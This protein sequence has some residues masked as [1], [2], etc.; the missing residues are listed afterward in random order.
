MAIVQNKATE[1]GD[2]ILIETAIPIVGLTALSSFT[3]STVDETV[4]RSFLRE[5]RYAINGSPYSEWIELTNL[6]L[7]NVSLDGADLLA[8]QYRYT[9]IGSDLTDEL[10]WNS[11]TVTTSGD[12]PDDGPAFSESVFSQFFTSLDVRVLGWAL[13]VLE[14]IYAKGL[15]PEVV[16]RRKGGDDSHFLHFFRPCCVFF[17]YLV[18][19]GRAFE[20]FKNDSVLAEKY[21]A[22]KGSFTCGN[23][24]LD[25]LVNVIINL[26]RTRSK[27]GTTAMYKPAN[28]DFPVDGEMLRLLA[29]TE[30]DYFKIGLAHQKY[31]GW[32][33]DNSSP[34]YRGLSGRKD[35]S[36]SYETTEDIND[37]AKYPTFGNGDMAL[38]TSGA[39]K[40]LEI[41]NVPA[42]EI[43]GIGDPDLDFKIVI[44]PKLTYEVTCFVSQDVLDNVL[45]FGCLGFDAN[46]NPVE[47]TDVT[48]ST[49]DRSLFFS[50]RSVQKVDTYFF[51]RGIIYRH[52]TADV[53]EAL[54]LNVGF[55]QPIRFR[56]SCN[57]IIPYIVL[58]NSAGVSPSNKVRIWNISVNPIATDYNR[59]YLDN[60]DWFDLFVKNNNG[61]YS[62]E[63]LYAIFRRYFISYG[64]SF[65]VTHTGL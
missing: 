54:A 49:L 14:K 33:L 15:V 56:E 61:S 5:F 44:D 11:I 38:V 55:G 51:I 35:L 40:V 42:T 45:T 22:N 53:T 64:C 4:N 13:N 46:G 18:E 43:T 58:D 29:W 52:D 27:R 7:S 20:F 63:D 17:A 65:G 9:R 36:S 39:K 1:Y 62:R 6:N 12:M 24:T 8:I 50:Q 16:E 30:N 28:N 47:F 59:G 37:L 48:D 21:L 41:S 60:T 3:D 34:E 23:E 31:A 2:V 19:F 10:E 32:C 25:E 26:L 57:S